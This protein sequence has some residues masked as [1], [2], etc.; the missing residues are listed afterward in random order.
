MSFAKL[1][2]KRG[3]ITQNRSISIDE[4]LEICKAGDLLLFCGYGAISEFFKFATNSRATH[5]GIIVE[6]DGKKYFAETYTGNDGVNDVISGK[7]GINCR[8]TALRERLEAYDCDKIELRQLIVAN[9]KDAEGLPK[10][11]ENAVLHAREHV[12]YDLNP[13]HFLDAIERRTFDNS[14][15]HHAL[16]KMSE[17]MIEMEKQKTAAA[18]TGAI[19]GKTSAEHT[20]KEQAAMLYL[21][22]SAFVAFVYSR[23]GVLMKTKD[24]KWH[25]RNYF[26]SD[27]VSGSKLPFEHGFILS[28]F[29][30]TVVRPRDAAAI[31]NQNDLF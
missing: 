11:I 6:I 28:P 18:T 10:K 7:Q 17:E 20:K 19:T 29:D 4:L 8:V 27:F 24:S 16:V 13:K 9:D 21:W 15:H 3:I 14:H 5:I 25:D 31:T 23:C 2:K 30:I 26:P 1:A 22:C 12:V